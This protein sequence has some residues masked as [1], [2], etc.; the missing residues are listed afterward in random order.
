M[1]RQLHKL[2][3]KTV[4]NLKEPG[5][6]PDGGNLYFQVTKTGVR[7]WLFKFML[8]GKAREMGLGPYPTV[9]LADARARAADARK[10]KE[11][12]VD[13]IEA[14]RPSKE[15]VTTAPEV[16]KTT[17]KE[18][19]EIY[20]ERHREKHS[21]E[22][23]AEQWPSTMQRFVYPFIGDM[24]VATVDTDHIEAI[25]K[26]IWWSTTD[27]ASRV[28][29]RIE[30]ILDWAKVKKFRTG[31]NPAR[32][33]GNIEHLFPAKGDIHTV[34]HFT[35]LPYPEL[36]DFWKRLA[37]EDGHSPRALMY[38]IL[39]VARNEETVELAWSEVDLENRIITLPPRR[40]K[41]G[42]RS[43]KEH[44]I[45]LSEPVVTILQRQLLKRKNDFV[46]PG[47]VGNK[48]MVEGNL[49]AVLKRMKRTDLDPHGFRSSF[50]T[51]A[52]ETTN[53]DHDAVELAMAHTVGDKIYQAYMR[54]D[55]FVKR[56]ALMDAWAS[57][58]VG[59]K[60]LDA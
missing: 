37:A 10:L 17:F 11:Q 22:K 29:G 14:K 49:R 41:A 25:L 54:G 21:N 1:G 35:M 48:P 53:H 32:W 60:S 5:R 46:F 19:A 20:I 30:S 28:L 52:L 55:M 15:S 36:P 6:Y 34:E 39:T 13:P 26:P 44:R 27:T 59:E 51:W 38:K 2:S 18:C 33:K 45:P 31:D 23:H 9:S 8:A 57:F 56:V 40:H 50:K 47:Q 42:I 16:K 4:E 58:V 3:T 12:G 7:S 43:G 24:D